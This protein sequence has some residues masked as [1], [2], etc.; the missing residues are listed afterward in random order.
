MRAVVLHEVAGARSVADDLADAGACPRPSPNTV[1][2]A[3]AAALMRMAGAVWSVDIW[4]WTTFCPARKTALP[5]VEIAVKTALVPFGER[6]WSAIRPPQPRRAPSAEPACQVDC[7]SLCDIR[8][9][10]SGT[11][12]ALVLRLGGR[13]DERADVGG[14]GKAARHSRPAP[15]APDAG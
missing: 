5:A 2:C 3:M 14:D 4:Y 15:A 1:R 7:W 13:H 10:G 11:L 6:N 8:F 12:T 9:A